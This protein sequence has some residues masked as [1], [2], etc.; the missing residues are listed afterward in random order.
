MASTASSDGGPQQL[1]AQL[2]EVLGTTIALLSVPAL[3]AISAVGLLLLAWCIPCAVADESEDVEQGNSASKG[4]GGHTARLDVLIKQGR[5]I[6][7]EIEDHLSKSV[8]LRCCHPLRPFVCCL[9]STG[10]IRLKMWFPTLMTPMAQQKLAVLRSR[11]AANRKEIIEVNDS[12]RAEYRKWNVL[13]WCYFW[14]LAL[15]QVS[16]LILSM[17]Y[18]GGILVAQGLDQV[19]AMFPVLAP[20]VGV[21]KTGLWLVKSV[22]DALQSTIVQ[23]LG[24]K[25]KQ[26]DEASILGV[27]SWEDCGSWNGFWASVLPYTLFALTLAGC[28]FTLWITVQRISTRRE[29]KRFNAAVRAKLLKLPSGRALGNTML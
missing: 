15:P 4:G 26:C 5:R 6:H 8:E 12:R 16:L 22:S 9:Q 25:Y 24:K 21:A 1:P 7:D 18:F 11:M 2:A 3:L 19:S 20:L 27:V 29:N 14:V 28:G 10:V 23:F 17:P 13:D